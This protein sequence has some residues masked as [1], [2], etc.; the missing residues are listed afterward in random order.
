[1]LKVLTAEQMREVDRL[2]TERYGVPSII[3]MENAA[4]AVAG[5]ITQ[6]L[7]GNVA[8][9]KVLILVGKG[10]NGGDG[11]ALARIMGNLGADITAC[12][13]FPDD[14]FAEDAKQNLR[15]LRNIHS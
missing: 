2:T 7:A 1:M 3:L 5:A 11:L 8:G 14:E 12:M 6:R 10:N 13:M 4:W 15:I 9:K